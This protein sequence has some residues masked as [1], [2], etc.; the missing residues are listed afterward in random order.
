LADLLPEHFMKKSVLLRSLACLCLLL[1][2]CGKDDKN[3]NGAHATSVALETVDAGGCL[4]VPAYFNQIRGMDPGLPVWEIATDFNLKSDRPIRAK[5]DELMAYSTFTFARKPLS[6]FQEFTGLSQNG[7][8]SLTLTAADGTEETFPIKARSPTS[9]E[10]EAEDGRSYQY[11]WLSPTRMVID[12]RYHAYDLPCGNPNPALIRQRRVLDWS[13][14]SPE[15]FD[16]AADPFSI[17]REYLALVGRAVGVPVDSFYEGGAPSA[18]SLIDLAGKPP[19]P[20]LLSCPDGT[21]PPA[22]PETPPD[23]G[24]DSGEPLPAPAP[25]GAI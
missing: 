19:L 4:N 17:S 6:S 16:L 21:L 23:E 7:C 9:V 20:E 2:S 3:A 12:V 15:S 22:P 5:F 25:P 14:S 24:G 11:T 18:A 8:D 1:F 10:A 13:Q